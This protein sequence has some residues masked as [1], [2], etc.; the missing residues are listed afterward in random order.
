MRYNEMQQGKRRRR[1]DDGEESGDISL[2]DWEDED[3]SKRRRPVFVETS[4]V[5]HGGSSKRRI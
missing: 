2:V 5:Q 3:Y 4:H 1:T